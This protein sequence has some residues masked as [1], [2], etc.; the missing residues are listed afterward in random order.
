MQIDSGAS[1]SEIK[2]AE[3]HVWDEDVRE[4]NNPLPM[5]WLYLFIITIVWSA[6]YLIYYPGMGDFAGVGGWSQEQQYAD[7]VATA[8]AQ[9]GPIFAAFGAT[10]I[11]QL[12]NNS[13][14]LS[15]GASLYQNY[16]S[17]CHGSTAQGARVFP[18]SPMT[19]GCMAANL[20]R[21]NNQSWRAAP[22][23]CRRWVV[24]LQ[25]MLRLT[26]W[27]A[28]CARCLTARTPIHRRTVN[29]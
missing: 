6:F 27:F 14:A 16:C 11:E 8:E 28:T 29:T 18:I 23:L 13:D 15:I 3:G 10:P 20:R 19:N 12:A 21:S 5:W 7:E 24:Y 17:Q 9:Y 2:E 22:A 26:K 25:T 4:L 1:E